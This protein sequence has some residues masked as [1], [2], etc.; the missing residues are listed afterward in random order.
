[1]PAYIIPRK[2]NRSSLIL[3]ASYNYRADLLASRDIEAGA[4]AAITS[5]TCSRQWRKN[6]SYLSFKN[7][8][9]MIVYSSATKDS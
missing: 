5:F 6:K 3:L 8:L 1:M 7:G 9:S 4:A 2:A